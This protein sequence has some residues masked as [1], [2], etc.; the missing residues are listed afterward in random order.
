MKPLPALFALLAATWLL[1]ACTKTAP[2][3]TIPDSAPIVAGLRTSEA[4]VTGQLVEVRQAMHDAREAAAGTEAAPAVEAADAR[5][6]TALEAISEARRAADPAALEKHLAELHRAID[7]LRAALNRA[8][9]EIDHLKDAET[10]RMV[11]ILLWLGVGASLFTI[12]S[13]AAIF[14]TIPLISAT[15]GPRL[16]ILGGI[17]AAGCFSIARLLSWIHA[18][19]NIATGLAALFVGAIVCGLWFNHI[20]HRQDT[21]K[22][23]AE[24]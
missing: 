20:R 11:R 21:R 7:Q 4:T 15:T 3:I 1:A 24:A 14:T 9:A 13:V 10:M 2:T 17:L 12:A 18:H 16:A 5:T 19:P 23:A 22:A 6:E 8:L